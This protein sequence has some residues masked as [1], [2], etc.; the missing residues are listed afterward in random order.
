MKI[1]EW[2][3]FKEQECTIG[4][5]KWNVARLITLSHKFPVMEIPLNH[6][7]V[8]MIYE[9]LTLREFVMHMKAIVGANLEYPIILDEDGV[10]M[11]GRHRI[12]KA[13]FEGRSSI[14]AVRFDTNPSP[15][16]VTE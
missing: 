5:H 7:D 6:L 9:K 14:K 1:P 15:D 3:D 2:L 16:K 12:M 8:W 13:M 11:D 4:K 10:L